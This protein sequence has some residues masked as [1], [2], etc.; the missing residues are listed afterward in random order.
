MLQNH[1]ILMAVQKYGS[2]FDFA[3]QQDN[4]GPHKTKSVASFLVGNNINVMK[5]PAQSLNPNRIRN[6]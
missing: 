6:A 2:T 1:V 4:S 5:W 3:F